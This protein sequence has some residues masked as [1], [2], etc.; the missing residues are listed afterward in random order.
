MPPEVYFG[1]KPENGDVG[2]KTN[3]IGQVQLD[4]IPPGHYYMLVWTVYNWLSVFESP[5]SPEPLLITIEAGDQLELGVLYS[6]W[7]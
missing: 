2:G 5:D 7:P 6:N 1:P 4:Q 3:L